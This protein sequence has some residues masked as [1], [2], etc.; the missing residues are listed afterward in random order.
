[1]PEVIVIELIEHIEY[2]LELLVLQLVK[3]VIVFAVFVD[4]LDYVFAHLQH[5]LLRHF[6]ILILH[7]SAHSIDLFAVT[8]LNLMD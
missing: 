7:L 1:M 6:L 8:V 4:V 2:L 5:M 3:L